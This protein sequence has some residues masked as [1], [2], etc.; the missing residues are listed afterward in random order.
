MDL[1]SG[2]RP[3]AE[4][5]RNGDLGAAALNRQLDDVARLVVEEQ[6]VGEGILGGDRVAI[7]RR[8]HVAGL[9][10]RGLAGRA[11]L[12]RDDLD[13]AAILGRLALDADVGAVVF[14]GFDDR[15]DDM[16]GCGWFPG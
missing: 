1:L 12:D 6:L 9:Q 8:D 15:V 10:T 11:G 2:R 3:H 14:A 7:D 16:A 13:A 5:H 4:G